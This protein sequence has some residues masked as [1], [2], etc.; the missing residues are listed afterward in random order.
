MLGTSFGLKLR[1]LMFRREFAPFDALWL[2]PT[3][4]IHMF[5]VRFPIDLVWLDGELRVVGAVEAIRPWRLARCRGAESVLEA[6][7]ETLQRTQTQVGD[8]LAFGAFA[9]RVPRAG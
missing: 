6:P 3:A 7:V 4:E 5:W 2:A 9:G 1:G 8:A